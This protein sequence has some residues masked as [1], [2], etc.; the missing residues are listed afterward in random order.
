MI[1]DYS[2]NGTVT[3]ISLCFQFFYSDTRIIID[4]AL[5][6]IIGLPVRVSSSISSRP[7]R[8]HLD[9]LATVLKEGASSPKTVHYSSE[10]K[11]N[12]IN[13]HIKLKKHV[14]L[15]SLHIYVYRWLGITKEKKERE[16]KNERKKG[17]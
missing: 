6:S 11:T 16:K 4:N 1:G 12:N 15:L 10:A 8:N 7:S 13:I 14:A 5:D 3:K 17:E 2:L 9:H